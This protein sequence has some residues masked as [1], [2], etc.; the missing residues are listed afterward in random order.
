MGDVSEAPS[1]VTTAQDASQTGTRSSNT[2][3]K[4]STR[5]VACISLLSHQLR[6]EVS[7][8]GI[9]AALKLSECIQYVIYAS[10]LRTWH[11]STVS[12]I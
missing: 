3:T 10:H 4:V 5:D 1:N 9:K 11:P 12:L 8:K 2:R 7:K 6:H